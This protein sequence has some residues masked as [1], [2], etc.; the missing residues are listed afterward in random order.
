MQ[1]HRRT[2]LTP[3]E[4]EVYDLLQQ[5]LKHKE[6]AQELGISLQRVGALHRNLR[7]RILNSQEMQ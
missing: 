3:R 5:G 7:L 2:E 6:I 4:Q 1:G